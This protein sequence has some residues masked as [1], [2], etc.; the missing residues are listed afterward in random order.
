MFPKALKQRRRPYDCSDS[1]DQWLP[2]N[3]KNNYFDL[4]LEHLRVILVR[5][6]ARRG[7]GCKTISRGT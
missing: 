7:V 2:S 1:E 5:C 3:T 6:E 4:D